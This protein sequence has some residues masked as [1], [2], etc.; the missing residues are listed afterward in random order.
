MA[1]GT[2]AVDAAVYTAIPGYPDN[3]HGPV[4]V[5]RRVTIRNGADAVDPRRAFEAASCD[6]RHAAT[7]AGDLLEDG[8]TGGL[9]SLAGEAGA[10]GPC[11]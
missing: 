10:A 1:I 11:P 3:V 6:A 8:V 2:G 7:P 9:L 4:A 5:L